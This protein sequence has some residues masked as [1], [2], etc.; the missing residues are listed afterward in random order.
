MIRP[1]E[2]PAP[3]PVQIDAKYL[4]GAP[5]AN[6]PVKSEVVIAAMAGPEELAVLV[7]LEPAGEGA[8]AASVES[9]LP[10]AIFFLG[11]RLAGAR[12]WPQ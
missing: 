4:Y 1:F 9:L 8:P 3:L 7:L 5:A 11:T 12:D 6:L 2:P 10:P